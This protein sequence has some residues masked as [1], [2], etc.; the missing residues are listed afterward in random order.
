L[1]CKSLFRVTSGNLYIPSLTGE[2]EMP[3]HASE[4]GSNGILPI[5]T[6]SEVRRGYLEIR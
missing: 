5:W 4:V 1:G 2:H 3:V 6:K